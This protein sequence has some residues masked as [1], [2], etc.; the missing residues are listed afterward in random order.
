MVARDDAARSPAA[1]ESGL[2]W[3]VAALLVYGTLAAGAFAALAPGLASAG[4]ALVQPHA[5]EPT[6]SAP[7]G[8]LFIGSVLLVLLWDLG[9][10][11]LAGA[12]PGLRRYGTLLALVAAAGVWRRQVTAPVLAPMDDALRHAALRAANALQVAYRR[13]GRYPGTVEALGLELPEAARRTGLWRRGLQA[14][15]THATFAPGA[16]EPRFTDEGQGPGTVV[17]AV[18]ASRQRFWVTAFVLDHS[19]EVTP[20]SDGSGHVLTLAGAVGRPVSRGPAAF[21]EY[22]RKM[23]LPVPGSPPEE[24]LRKP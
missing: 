18:D 3:R 24:P 13:D 9:C 15:E 19:G 10:R 5:Y 8:W 7:W 2:S 16:N 12:R 11:L 6:L 4:R 17:V 23:A 22:P 20:V 1:Q 14:V 21:F